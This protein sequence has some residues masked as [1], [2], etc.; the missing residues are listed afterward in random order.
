M[1]KKVWAIIISIILL[2]VLFVVVI[3]NINKNYSNEPDMQVQ[4]DETVDLDAI[5]NDVDKNIKDIKNSIK[6]NK[7]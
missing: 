7:E 3:T 2:V 6:E 5:R 1:K 4:R